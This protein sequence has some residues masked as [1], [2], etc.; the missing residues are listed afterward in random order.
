MAR[1]AASA[2]TPYPVRSRAYSLPTVATPTIMATLPMALW[3]NSLWPMLRVLCAA[4]PDTVLR[5]GQL[6]EYHRPPWREPPAKP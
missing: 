1:P 2:W 6:L 4:P 5:A 3:L